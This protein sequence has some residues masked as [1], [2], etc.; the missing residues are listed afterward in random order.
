MY[1][2][3][4]VPRANDRKAACQKIRTKAIK[5]ATHAQENQKRHYDRRR[6]PAPTYTIGDEVWLQ[7]GTSV[8]GKK[9]L[10]KFDRPFIITQR[11]GEN[12]CRVNTSDANFTLDKR[13]RNNFAVRVSR[14][15]KAVVPLQV[16]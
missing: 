15:K 12:I 13:K 5:K 3:I 9:L 10:P 4:I 11:V 2:P 1:A 14:L 8:P 7:R 6:R 16:Q